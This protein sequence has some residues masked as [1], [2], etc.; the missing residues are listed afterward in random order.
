[1]KVEWITQQE[2]LLKAHTS[3]MS[4][5]AQLPPTLY[6]Q[7]GVCGVWTPKQVV[8][9]LVGWDLEAT[10]GFRALLAGEPEQ[11]VQDVDVFN[12]QSVDQRADL[13]WQETLQQLSSA[14]ASFQQA[15]DALVVAQHVAPG[16]LGWLH[17]RIEDYHTHT[18][19]LQ[20]WL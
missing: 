2:G 20:A 5:A 10:R 7:T 18:A 8:A 11:F 13:S 4:V 1:M 9:H 19:Q 6:D 3:F 16:Y 12:H 17:G 14:Y 15:I